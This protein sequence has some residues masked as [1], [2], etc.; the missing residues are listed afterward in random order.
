VTLASQHEDDTRAIRHFLDRFRSYS[1][2]NALL[3]ILTKGVFFKYALFS[4]GKTQLNAHF[5]GAP[6][7][8]LQRLFET[9]IPEFARNAMVQLSLFD[10]APYQSKESEVFVAKRLS[11]LDFGNPDSV[12]AFRTFYD[13]CLEYSMKSF[14]ERGVVTSTSKEL[15]FL[16]MLLLR[17]EPGG[18]IY[19]PCFGLGECFLWS[20]DASQR[21]RTNLIGRERNLEVYLRAL[22]RLLLAGRS[23]DFLSHGTCYEQ[24]WSEQLRQYIAGGAQYI[25]ANP[26]FNESVNQVLVSESG[27][28]TKHSDVIILDHILSNLAPGGRAVIVVPNSTLTR[29]GVHKLLRKRMLSDFFVEAVVELPRD[30]FR[31]TSIP[32]NMLVISR[33]QPKS[34]ILFVSR[35]LSEQVISEGYTSKISQ[36]LVNLLEA[37]AGNQS[38]AQANID[39]YNN[40]F[41]Y[42]VETSSRYRSSQDLAELCILNNPSMKLSEL[43]KKEITDFESFRK[44]FGRYTKLAWLVSTKTIEEFGL[45]L[46]VR[47]QDAKLALDD[48][49]KNAM[50]LRNGAR[51]VS[52]GE[53]ADCFF[54]VAY[55]SSDIEPVRDAEKT[56][57]DYITVIKGQNVSDSLQK[58]EW[59]GTLKPS[60]NALSDERAVKI[61]QT[62]YLRAGD[63]LLGAIGRGKIA[64]VPEGFRKSVA[65]NTVLVIRPESPEYLSDYLSLL[66]SSQLYRDW[67][68]DQASSIGDVSRINPRLIRSLPIVI[69]TQ[70]D[71]ERLLLAL[72]GGEDAATLL[73]HWYALEKRNDWQELAL[74]VFPEIKSSSPTARVS[75]TAHKWAQIENW[76]TWVHVFIESDAKFV[77]PVREWI[78]EWM[79]IC[80]ELIASRGITSSL[81][82]V[83]MLQATQHRIHTSTAREGLEAYCYG[84]SSPTD[85]DLLLDCATRLTEIVTELIR[86]EI[87]MVTNSTKI[88][89]LVEPPIVNVGSSETI[90]IQVSND[91]SFYL[92]DFQMD[93]FP[94]D[95]RIV[96]PIFGP[97]ERLRC[98]VKVDSSTSGKREFRVIWNARNLDGKSIKGAL[99]IPLEV[100]DSPCKEEFGASPYII[101]NPVGADMFFGRKDVLEKIER[102]L[103]KGSSGVILLEGNRRVGKTS[104]L[105]HLDETDL[106]NGFITAYWTMQA[107]T[108]S[109][110][111][112]GIT[113][114]QFFYRIARILILS[115]YKAK[116]SFTVP[117]IGDVTQALSLAKLYNVL[118]QEF[119]SEFNSDQAFDLL[120]QCIESIFDSVPDLSLV[121]MI[122]EFDKLHEGI[123]NG[124]TSAFVPGNLRSIIHKY[125]RLSV[126]IA[127][128]TKLKR[129]REDY[130][131]ALFGLGTKISVEGLDTHSA[132]NLVTK[133]VEGKLAFGGNAEKIVQLCGNHPFLIQKFCDDVFQICAEQNKRS[134]TAPVLEAATSLFIETDEHFRFLW[135]FIASNFRRYLTI[136]VDELS[137]ERALVTIQVI[138]EKLRSEG[139]SVPIGKLGN[140][141]E[142]LCDLG[143][144]S[145]KKEHDSKIYNLV[146]PLFGRW[147]S[148]NRDSAGYK[149]DAL[150]E[151]GEWR[152]KNE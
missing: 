32:G 18:T 49:N 29:D 63:I 35:R 130:W 94:G 118:G 79:F 19:D 11:E 46:S 40:A 111:A 114:E 10:K 53:I 103:R 77:S 69:P 115:L 62:Q 50:R 119:R 122:D 24:G 136:K 147:V 108:G 45:D 1:D 91:G 71:C 6:R 127:G 84:P 149:A 116:K 13:N 25:V 55:V 133:P 140:E 97:G 39:L 105:K 144:L 72:S 134:V 76:L 83:I 139:V 101:G 67:I 37:R 88:V 126:V 86:S 56:G 148:L 145:L 78:A 68:Q 113:D 128:T 74:R 107:A 90:S 38:A 137:Q 89:G 123:E 60:A 27:I 102:R 26:P 54:G 9:E 4:K 8:N 2:L 121:L 104:I 41:S 81:N 43:Q 28:K 95:I 82:R 59:V 48:F 150:V 34:D 93:L 51:L 141:L 31:L 92:R 85:S 42:E 87:H 61:P 110:D 66:L 109:K 73:S 99:E 12:S 142:A 129:L 3:N 64:I 7:E 135:D 96:E 125:S 17:F 112:G 36:A 5:T 30:A 65:T 80:N 132:L 117:V 44:E 124:V 106:L 131:S 58:E 138:D 57:Y 143:I 22:A 33:Q 146:V 120:D 152:E 23:V 14:A 98:S 100:V 75:L 15:A 151:L 70:A 52:L 21:D 47:P 16:Q 20:Q